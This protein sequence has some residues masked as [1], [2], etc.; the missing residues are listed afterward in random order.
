MKKRD[1]QAATFNLTNQETLQLAIEAGIIDI[2][3]I[4]QSVE[5]KQRKE[6]LDKHPYS[7]WQDAKGLWVTYLPDDNAPEG[8]IRRKRKDLKKLEDLIV[9]FYYQQ[10]EKIYFKD[11]FV[12][13][14]NKKL[15]YNEIKKQSYDRYYNDFIRFFSSDH[16]V[17]TKL[18]KNITYADLEDF[19]KTNIRD[20][21]LTP[22]TYSGLRTLI[23]GTF[24]YGKNN[25]YTGLSMTE[26]FGDL[27]LPKNIF[28]HKV[29][30]IDELVFMEDE[31]PIIVSYLKSHIDI[32]NMALLLQFQTGIRIG[33]LS[34]LKPIDIG[35]GYI[36]LR[37]TECK[38]RNEDNKWVVD[39][40]DHAKT[41]AGNRDIYFPDTAIWT[42]AQI[43]KL[44]PNGE[45]LFMNKGKRIRSTTL[46]KRLSSVCEKVKIVPRSSHKIRSTYGTELIDSDVNESF[47]AEQMGHTD[48]STTK[49]YYYY[50]NQRQKNKLKQINNAIKY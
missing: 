16:A 11:V 24:I 5:V 42:L 21:C 25:G 28:T 6:I 39:V 10:T 33:E 27:Q 18:F 34:A 3:D 26:F 40:Q 23:R 2:V 45:F 37:R 12:E 47:I 41:I 9:S 15:S 31:I 46:N 17:C 7:I 20:K 48:I 38:Y 44:N 1:S 50:S 14:L 4:A 22:K 19:I 29:I 32:W 8:R 49:K 35:E 36:S 13:W 43:Q 30:C